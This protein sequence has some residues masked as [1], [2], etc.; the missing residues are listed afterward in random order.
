MSTLFPID[1]EAL[2]EESYR[3]L[4][5][6]CRRYRPSKVFVCFSGGDDSLTAAILASK[7]ENF[8]GCVHINTGISIPDA[9]EFVRETC[10][11]QKWPLIELHPTDKDYEEFV[12][13]YGFPGPAAHRYCYVWLKERALNWFVSNVAKNSIHDRVMLVT[14]VRAQESRR[15]MGKTVKIQRDNCKVWVAPLFHWSKADCLK[16]ISQNGVERSPVAKLL[17]MSG[18]C[19]CGS[20]ADNSR[21]NELGEIRLWY[22]GVAARIEDLQEKA[23]RRGVYCK[24][25]VKP[26]E[27][28]RFLTDEDLPLLMMCQQCDAL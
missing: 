10:H 8:T 13:E 11:Q 27:E 12:L 5:V 7:L 25:G 23:R 16:Y 26:P 9:N 21:T 24:W 2:I 4:D 22:P 1:H 14:G 6:A 20:F 18:E 19:L 3:I 17:H 28:K 15:R